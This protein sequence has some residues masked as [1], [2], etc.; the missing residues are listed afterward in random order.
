MARIK[1]E[2]GEGCLGR[3]SHR[4]K[5]K[6]KTNKTAWRRR[7][8]PVHT[9]NKRMLHMVGRLSQPNTSQTMPKPMFHPKSKPKQIIC[10]LGK[11]RMSQNHPL[12]AEFQPS[13]H[14][15]SN[16]RYNVSVPCNAR[17]QPHVVSSP[18]MPSCLQSA[19][20]R[21]SHNVLHC[22]VEQRERKVCLQMPNHAHKKCGMAYIEKRRQ[23]VRI[24]KPML[25]VEHVK[26]NAKATH[27]ESSKMCER[28]EL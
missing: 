3:T 15:C 10:L 24:T 26:E 21:C 12:R 20:V 14:P 17:Q 7:T 13:N 23:R 11:T 28:Q 19:Q 1:G 25:V 27:R 4:L 16:S 8:S 5:T 6:T 22:M 18:P 2:G 9:P